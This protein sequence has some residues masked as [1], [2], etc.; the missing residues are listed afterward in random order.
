[1]LA[2]EMWLL[3][4]WRDELV[5]VEGC[6]DGKETVMIWNGSECTDLHRIS[7]HGIYCWCSVI[8]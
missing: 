6:K 1:M 7:D 2:V 3:F 8:G 4:G 5:G